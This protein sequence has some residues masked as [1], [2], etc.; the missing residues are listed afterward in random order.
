MGIGESG[1][2][3]R[4]DSK[5]SKTSLCGRIPTRPDKPTIAP[6]IERFFWHRLRF[7]P[8]RKVVSSQM[9]FAIF[10][11]M[12]WVYNT[13]AYPHYSP[14]I[15]NSC[16]MHRKKKLKENQETQIKRR[17]SN[18]NAGHVFRSLGNGTVRVPPT[19]HFSIKYSE[20]LSRKF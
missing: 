3:D 17:I 14:S 4:D 2:S 20:G 6:E 9:A 10:G 8:K 1:V 19:A 16:Q 13:N 15:P 5:P 7:R 11:Y 18:A 12:K